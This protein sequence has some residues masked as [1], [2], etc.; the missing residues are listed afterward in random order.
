M[1]GASESI[2]EFF[3]T[4]HDEIDALLAAVPFGAPQ[5]ALPLL[6]EFDRRLERH[7]RW[8]E[9]ILFPTAAEAAPFLGGGPIPVMLA[10]HEAVR[11]A[12]AAAVKAL[13]RGDAAAARR[14]VSTLTA[15]LTPHNDKE[16]G[17]LYPACDE[18]LSPVEA[19]VL[20]N[21]IRAAASQ[22]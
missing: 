3:A 1:N 15:C 8:E 2:S 21:R 12:K 7:I 19:E 11:G 9:E 16:E 14:A 6:R 17:I 22:G 4:D 10:E 20:L 13:E 5:E 18:A